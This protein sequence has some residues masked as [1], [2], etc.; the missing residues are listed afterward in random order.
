RHPHRGSLENSS[1][2]QQDLVDF[3]RRDVDAPPDDQIL[4]AAGD[5]DESVRVL[6]GEVAGLD[7]VGA[8][9]F[10]RSVVPQIAHRR[11]RPARRHFTFDAGRTWFTVGVD[12]SEFLVQRRDADRA[13]A[14]LV[15]AISAYPASLRHAVHL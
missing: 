2:F 12:D 13:D 6:D 8:N 15:G 1:M 7:A 5:A 3:D 4:D 11:V 9:G 14:I 10:D